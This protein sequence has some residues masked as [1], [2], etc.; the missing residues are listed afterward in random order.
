MHYA[1]LIEHELRSRCGYIPV[2]TA[3][4]ELYN[5]YEPR[6]F[7]ATWR[8]DDIQHFIY[9]GSDFGAHKYF[10]GKFGT[11]SPRAEQFSIAALIKYG[12]RNYRLKERD[13]Y[14]Y[15]TM[16]FGFERFDFAEKHVKPRIFLP[17]AEPDFL[18][19]F[20]VS[21]IEDKVFPV[22]R[23]ITGLETYMNLLAADVEPCPWFA[24]NPLVRVAQIV[25]LGC[26]LNVGKTELRRFMEPKDRLITRELALGSADPKS[27]D[28]DPRSCVD[29]F[30]DQL[31]TDWSRGVDKC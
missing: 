30:L 27:C 6:V 9:L 15:C 18:T 17:Q 7:T 10:V 3:A 25:A 23:P 11:R 13:P 24:V 29:S 1:E 28:A 14:I 22:I 16:A 26:Q 20:V 12:H 2:R 19:R 31:I 4:L 21:V 8:S 5:I